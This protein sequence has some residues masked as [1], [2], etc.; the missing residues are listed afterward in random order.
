MLLTIGDDSQ[1]RIYSFS[2]VCGTLNVGQQVTPVIADYRPQLFVLVVTE[3]TRSPFVLCR[4][5]VGF[6]NK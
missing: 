3:Q 4:L 2:A 1:T 6:S 5:N